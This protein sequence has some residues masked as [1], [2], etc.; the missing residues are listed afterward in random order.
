MDTETSNIPDIKVTRITTKRI[1]F[2]SGNKLQYAKLISYPSASKPTAGDA[3]VA[4]EYASAEY[5]KNCNGSET[6]AKAGDTYFISKKHGVE[7]FEK[8]MM[9]LYTKLRAVPNFQ[10]GKLHGLK[11]LSVARYS[12]FNCMGIIRGDVV[13]SVD[14]I[15]INMADGFTV[16]QYIKNT[17]QF[18]V[19]LLRKGEELIFQYRIFD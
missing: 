5:K 16:Y 15:P 17:N 2:I 14:D 3:P 19:K 6:F 4:D 10:D 8:N 11:I 9:D 18:S 1:E 7:H 12:F 13:I